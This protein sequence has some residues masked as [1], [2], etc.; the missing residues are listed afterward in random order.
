MSKAPTIIA[1]ASIANQTTATN[2]INT[3]EAA[4]AAAFSNTL[5]LDGSA[6]N[7]MTA[8][9][10]MNSQHILNLP[11]P[12]SAQEPVRLG[13]L[14]TTLPVITSIT[15]YG[16]SLLQSASAAAARTLLGISA[17]AQSVITLTTN[18]LMLTQLGITTAAQSVITQATNALML[19]QLGISTAAQSVITAA[20]NAL[21]LTQLGISTAAQS[22]ITQVS[23]AAM[24][25]QLGATTIGANL[26]GATTNN[27]AQQF[28]GMAS[29]SPA[30]NF[31]TVTASPFTYT[32]GVAPETIYVNGGTFSN[33]TVK[34]LLVSNASG[35][36]IPQTYQLWPGE[37]LTITY[38]VAPSL[39]RVIH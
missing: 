20:T 24:L 15:T 16:M 25:T 36:G 38:T 3:N 30:G 31:I 12:V 33:I 28:I 7:Q 13:D 17:A 29:P 34:G 8:S 22:V 10:D 1:L 26:F 9:L 5:S 2:T 6:P 37:T 14:G 35:G 39:G 19:T 21:M 27:L 32:A 23:N 4:L 18:A 11:A